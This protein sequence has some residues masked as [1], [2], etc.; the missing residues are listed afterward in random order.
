MVKF[1]NPEILS[2]ALSSNSGVAVL[3]HANDISLIVDADGI[4]HDVAVAPTAEILKKARRW[5]GKKWSDTV[6][7]ESVGKV[8]DLLKPKK[9]SKPFWRQVNHPDGDTDLA[10]SYLSVPLGEDGMIL[11]VGRELQRVAELQQRLLDAQH[12]L[13]RDY[14]RL[15]QA[16]IRYR[17]LFSMSSES[18][19]IRRRGQQ[20]Y[21]GGESCSSRVACCSRQQVDQPPV[22]TRLFRCE[23]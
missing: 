8:E 10:V 5:V 15:H 11:A 20:P 6:T 21:R 23:S 3:S 2:R 4:I 18:N 13:E 1:K 14:A 7:V 22:P 16:E 19:F 17:M 12:S 9:N